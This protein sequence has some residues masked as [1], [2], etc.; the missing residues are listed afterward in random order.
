MA[1][2]SN[3]LPG[4]E[5]SEDPS[6]EKR[7]G[8]QRSRTAGKD[9]ELRAK[10]ANCG[11]RSRTAGKDREVRAKDREL[12]AKNWASQSRTRFNVLNLVPPRTIKE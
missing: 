11:Q 4:Q 1:R 6:E 8:G 3:F 9:R 10:I 5:S 7:A 12:R 2:Q